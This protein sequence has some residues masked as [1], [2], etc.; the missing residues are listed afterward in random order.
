MTG[1]RSLK[2]VARPKSGSRGGMAG[3]KRGVAP[4]RGVAWSK[5][6]AVS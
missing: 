1:R 3:I 2:K 4:K 6:V 5:G